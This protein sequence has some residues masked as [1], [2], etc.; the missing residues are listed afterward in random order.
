M[1]M[2]GKSLHARIHDENC[3]VIRISSCPYETH[4]AGHW[5]A[6]AFVE[7][8]ELGYMLEIGPDLILLDHGPGAHH[9]L[10]ESASVQWMSPICSSAICTTTIARILSGYSSRAGSRCG[11]YTELKVYG[12]PP[13]RRMC[14]QLFGQDGAFCAG[15]ERA[16]QASGLNRYIS[17]ARGG[18]PPRKWPQPEIIE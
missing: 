2:T 1:W 14:E 8:C 3:A 16:H 17:F 7:A 4:P 10:L 5:H 6:D 12:P 18:R 15:L 13:V 11:P 9:R